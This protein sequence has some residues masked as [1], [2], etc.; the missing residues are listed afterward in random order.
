MTV[1]FIR[2]GEGGPV[3]IGVAGDVASRL[4]EFQTAHF[5]TLHIIR[6]MDGD[7]L[8]EREMH[9][10]FKHRHIRGEWFE[11]DPEMLT[12]VPDYSRAPSV[13]HTK[14][15]VWLKDKPMTEEEFGFLVGASQAAVSRYCLGQRV[16]RG[17]IMQAISMATNGEIEPNDFYRTA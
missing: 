16:P 4:A 11:F 3:K 12:V 17:R 1:Y 13:G 7:T 14:L 10:R 6:E 2:A 8:A 15:M 5:Q 9:R